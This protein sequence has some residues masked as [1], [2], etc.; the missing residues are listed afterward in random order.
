MKKITCQLLCA[1]SVALSCVSCGTLSGLGKDMQS[2][3]RTMEKTEHRR[4][5]GARSYYPQT[6][7]RPAHQV[8]PTPQPQATYPTY[9]TYAIGRR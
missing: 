8:A 9:P 2:M 6:V 5:W 1:A 4:V 3:G 7:Y